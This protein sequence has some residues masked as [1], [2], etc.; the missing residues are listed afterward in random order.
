MFLWVRVVLGILELMNIQDK[1]LRVRRRILAWYRRVGRD[2]PWRRTRDPYAIAV[3]EVMLQQTQVER[4]V[5]K[6]LAWR[7]AWPTTKS[8]ERA[9]LS[10]VLKL[11]S[12]LGYNSR[13]MR[14]RLAAREVM[15]KYNGHWPR[16]VAELEALPG[17]GSYTAAAI[18]TFAYHQRVPV[19]DTNVRRVIGRMFFGVRG[20]A[21]EKVLTNKVTKML[22]TTRPDIWNHALMDLG[23]MVC[24]A[25]RPKCEECSVKN[26]CLAYP[27]IL[28]QPPALKKTPNPKFRATNRFWRGRIIAVLSVNG[29]QSITGLK[30]K[31][32]VHGHLD[33]RRF[34]KL[35]SDLEKAGLIA[36]RQQTVSI[37]D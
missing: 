22:P 30:K 36:C 7:R 15:V 35:V 16:T 5:P 17:V 1:N 12:G 33:N 26:L 3:S 19:I 23:A 18:V 10:E 24:V 27:A 11:W 9:P 32:K 13:A 4:V 37:V 21:S 31:I 20:P 28:N 34:M 25:R 29:K 14:L 2:L 6:F 8:L